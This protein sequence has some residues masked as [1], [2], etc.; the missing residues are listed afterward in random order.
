MKVLML[1]HELRLPYDLSVVASTSEP[2]YAPVH[3]ERYVPTI[4]DRDPATGEIFHVFES[5][6]C[7]QYLAEVYDTEGLWRGRTVAERALV[8]SWTAYQTA[9]MGLHQNVLAQWDTLEARLSSDPAQHYIALKD[10]P[11]IADLAYLP[12][13]MPYMFEF[14]GV[15]M[16]RW[17]MIGGWY[18]RMK[19]RE[20]VRGVGEW[21]KGVGN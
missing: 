17:P 20:A 1:A 3:P 10:R 18:E 7:L 12:F 15:E 9:G 5:T 11:T 8:L 6:A 2:W 4:R 21:V 19:G 13:A 16:E 14:M